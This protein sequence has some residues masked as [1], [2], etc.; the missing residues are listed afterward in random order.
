MLCGVHI[1]KKFIFLTFF[2]SITL[3]ADDYSKTNILEYIVK[4]INNKTIHKI[5]SDDL[6]VKNSFSSLKNYQVVNDINKAELLVIKD[7]SSLKGYSFKGYIFVLDYNL[8][9][10]IPQSFGAFFWKKGRANI[11][12]IKPRI[13]KLHLI[14]SKELQEYVEERVW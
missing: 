6:S 7:K 1:L 10:E 5:W 12:F 4:N 9:N 13:D 2:L 14:L 8:L 11:V 3:L